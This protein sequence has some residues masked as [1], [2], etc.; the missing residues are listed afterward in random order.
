MLLGYNLFFVVA[1]TGYLMGVTQS[2]EYAEPEWY[3]DIWLAV[4]WVD[5]SCSY[6]LARSGKR[7]EPHIYVANWYYLAFILAVAMLHIVNNLAVPVSFLGSKSYS[8]VRG[9]AGCDDPVVVRPQRG[10]LLPHRRLPRHD[11]LLPAEARR[12]A[13]LLLPAVDHQLLGLIFM[14][15]WAGPHHLHYTA[16]PDWVQTL[17]MTFSI[18]LL[19][20]SWAR[21]DQRLMTLSGAWHKVRDDPTLRFMIVVGRVLRHGDLRRA[22]HGDQA[23]NSLSHYTDWTIGHVHAGAL[24][25]VALITFGAIYCLVPVAV[26]RRELYSLQAGRVAF[27]V[28]T[29]RHRHLRLRDVGLRHHPGADVA[30]LQRSSASSNTPSSRRWWRCIPTT[31]RG[32]SAGCCS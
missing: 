22:V 7:N 11:V 3:A 31:S 20:P 12:A 28:S 25:W 26:E 2:K 27:L 8:D 15:I 18:M 23:V 29:L 14:Y 32:R 6:F 5:Y 24:G 13:D 4:V 10:R 19:V 17:G 30:H 9:R 16:L 1:G 21:P